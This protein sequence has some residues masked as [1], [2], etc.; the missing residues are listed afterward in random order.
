MRSA[1]GLRR[2]VFVLPRSAPLEP[3]YGRYFVTGTSGGQTSGIGDEDLPEAQ[4]FPTK[5]GTSRVS[6][7]GDDER[8]LA[9]PTLAAES[10]DTTPRATATLCRYMSPEISAASL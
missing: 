9:A 3:G 8:S 6:G 4:I 2:G 7:G 10:S 1:G 5:R